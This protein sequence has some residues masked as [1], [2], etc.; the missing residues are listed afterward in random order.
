MARPSCV[1]M[2]ED[3]SALPACE[4]GTMANAKHLRK[5][6]QSV[7]TWNAWKKMSPE[8]T[9]DLTK[10]YLSEAD[11][12]GADLRWAKL[13]QAN[14]NGAL[15]TDAKLWEIQKA[16]WSIQ[17]SICEAVYWDEDGQERTTYSL[18]EPGKPGE[19][20]RLYADKTKI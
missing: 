15:L 1:P 3:T 4:V 6:K 14:L 7:N 16:G 17:G 20:E 5:L 8:T 11:L 18:G 19:F 12:S 10:A 13:I 9:I 2:A